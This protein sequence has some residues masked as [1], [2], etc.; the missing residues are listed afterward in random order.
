MAIFAILMPSPQPLLVEEIQRRF[1]LDHLS[2]S[3]TQWLISMTGTV[4]EL[5]A[6]LG[7]Y[8]VNEPNKP[9]TGNAIVFAISSYFG[10]APTSVWEW[11]KTKWET[12]SGG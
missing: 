5:T 7:I 2:V 4:V 6:K 9:S 1:P 10:R 11:I 3:D 8:D 12:S